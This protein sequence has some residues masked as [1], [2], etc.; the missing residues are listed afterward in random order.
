MARYR[1]T[2]VDEVTRI[3]YVEADSQEEAETLDLDNA[4]GG[5][6]HEVWEGKFSNAELADPE[7]KTA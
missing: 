7:E 5:E 4:I 6:I 2:F 3:F 1:I